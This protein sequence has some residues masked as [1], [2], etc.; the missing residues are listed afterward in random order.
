MDKSW[1][2]VE[3]EDKEAWDDFVK[4]SPQRSIFVQTKFLD[5]LQT[6][7]RLVSC[8][9]RGEIV[10]GVVFMLD[11]DGKPI[12]STFPFTQYQGVQLSNFS[13]L[14]THS[15]LSKE[16]VLLEYF[17]AELAARFSHFSLNHSWRL[18]DFRPFQWFNY[19]ERGGSRFAFDLRYSA[20]L[21][22]DDYKSHESYIA[23]VRSLRKREY[24]KGLKYLKY[25]TMSDANLL[26]ALYLK[27][28]DR[29]GLDVPGEE[30]KLL[31]SIAEKS[32]AEGFGM[33][34]C[35][36]LNDVPISASLFVYDDRAAYYLVG[37]NDPVGRGYGAGTFV[38]MN[39][40]RNAFDRGVA[41]I[42]FVGANSPN[43]GD[44]KISLNGVLKPHF[45]TVL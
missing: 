6:G 44:F 18:Q 5:A 38:I 1:E 32:C 29:Q 4:R 7:Y 41:E 33:L 16:F 35:A 21:S 25:V 40:I 10:A 12:C 22:A 30:I 36:T 45:T 11:A 39:M 23:T 17:V 37:A 28:F 13:D 3:Q 24:A 8:R 2:V 15:R 20:V 19:H 42:D 31:K 27:T 9:D 26:E 34:G 14:P 43:R